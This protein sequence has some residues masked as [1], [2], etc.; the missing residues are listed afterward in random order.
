MKMKF[1]I[2]I[3]S[4]ALL[5]GACQK[6]DKKNIADIE[7]Q[8]LA[9]GVRFDKLFLGIHLGMSSKDFYSVCWDLNKSGVLIESRNN[10]A[11]AYVFNKGEM[12]Y[13]A[14][15]D[16][17]PKFDL[18]KITEM[19]VLFSYKSWAPWNKELQSD[20]LIFDVKKLM[21]KWYGEG[22]I[23]LKDDNRGNSY[24]KIDGNRRITISLASEV[25]VR[26]LYTDLAATK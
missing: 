21:E 24:V 22:F 23:Y 15:M 8:E 10:S 16:F 9:K 26:V 7:K 3:L 13:P 11:T 1:Y 6:L 25:E 19:P 18:G 2:V 14:Q 5:I 12:D 20:K 17:Y 4:T